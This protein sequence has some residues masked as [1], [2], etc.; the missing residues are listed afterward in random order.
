MATLDGNYWESHKQFLIGLLLA[1]LGCALFFFVGSTDVRF[2]LQGL[3]EV[4]GRVI[5][6]ESYKPGRHSSYQ[7]LVKLDT[8]SGVL[9]LSQEA[10]GYFADRLSPGQSIR[11]WVNPPSDDQVQSSSRTVWQ[12]ERG[13]QVVMPV[14]EVGDRVLNRLLWDGGS[15]LIPL[16]GGLFMV[17]R[18]L[19]RYHA[20]D[21]AG[22]E[23]EEGKSA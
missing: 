23:H 6:A 11:A 20:D 10:S 17:G 19:A 4:R 14:M 1:G 8:G 15:A 22:Q 12:I 21:A 7:L 18:H 9:R 2:D 16:L 13:S 5:E 3:Q